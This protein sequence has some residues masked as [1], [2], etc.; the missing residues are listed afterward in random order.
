[1]TEL[2]PDDAEYISA[3]APMAPHGKRA[4]GLKWYE[5]EDT[6]PAPDDVQELH[7]QAVERYELDAIPLGHKVATVYLDADGSVIEDATR[8]KDPSDVATRR[9]WSG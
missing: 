7:E 8:W 9:E 4:F 2:G 6:E 1:M 5:N 3:L